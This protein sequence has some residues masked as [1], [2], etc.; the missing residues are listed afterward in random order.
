MCLCFTCRGAERPPAEL[1][2]GDQRSAQSR[3]H[4]GGPPRQ[5]GRTDQVQS[6]RLEGRVGPRR[7]LVW[8]TRGVQ[9]WMV[10]SDGSCLWLWWTCHCAL[11]NHTFTVWFHESVKSKPPNI[12][13]PT[14][15]FNIFRLFWGLEIVFHQFS[16]GLL[17]HTA[18]FQDFQ[19]SF[20]V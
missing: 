5:T 1:C 4:Q 12:Q 2:G 9:H 3:V 19:P 14:N 18:V 15:W 6:E 17:K 8:R 7:R 16:N 10:R 20:P 13:T 11:E